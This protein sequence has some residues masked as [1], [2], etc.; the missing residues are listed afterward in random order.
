[1]EDRDLAFPDVVKLRPNNKYGTYAVILNDNPQDSLGASRSARPILVGVEPPFGPGIA[2]TLYFYE[3]VEYVGPA[4][5]F[6]LLTHGC[7]KVRSLAKELLNDTG[8]I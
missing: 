7:E 6:E 1:M 8:P 4:S 5:Y 3:I 2:C